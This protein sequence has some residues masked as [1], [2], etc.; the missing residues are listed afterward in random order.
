[1]DLATISSFWPTDWVIIAAV[2]VLVA[3]ES[4]RAGTTRAATLAL[5][6]P[7]S[8]YLYEALSKAYLLAPLVQDISIPYGKAI[9][10]CVLFF[11]VYF[12]SSRIVSSFDVGGGIL[13]AVLSALATVI[14][15]LLVWAQ[16]PGL[17]DIWAFGAALDSAFGDLYR[18]YWALSALGI[19][20]FARS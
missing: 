17:H 13:P 18:F 8:L 4:F 5:S 3:L 20:A 9:I 11:V 12:F 14:L 1:M 6:L 19:L 16:V 10:F 7:I 2:M 15:L